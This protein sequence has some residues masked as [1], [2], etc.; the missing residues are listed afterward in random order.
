MK[1]NILA[2]TLSS[3]FVALSTQASTNSVT[4]AGTVTNVTCD[5][6]IE[7]AGAIIPSQQINLG[8]VGLNKTGDAVTFKILS[9]DPENGGPCTSATNGATMLWTAA[10]FDSNGLMNASGT[11][12]DA[13]ATILAKPSIGTNQAI[14]GPSPSV[15]FPAEDITTNGMS[16]EAS[17]VGGA[18]PGTYTSVATYSIAY[19]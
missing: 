3:C 18:I 10:N 2:I 15:D 4:F 7:T 12:T 19:K 5:T 14:T 17:L 9:V 11:A 16:F 6:Q 1:K 8:T 13:Y